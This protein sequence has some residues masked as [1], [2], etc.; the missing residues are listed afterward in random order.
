M[1]VLQECPVCNNKQSLK[2]IECKCGVNLVSKKKQGKIK[3]WIQYRLPGGKQRKEFVGYSIEDAKTADG[4]RK[5]QK[6]EGRIFDILPEAKTTFEQLADWY[7][8]LT[9]IKELGYYKDLKNN[10][11]SFNEV[12]GGGLN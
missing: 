3:Y 8:N 12:F 7:I 11:N 4:K 5:T 2:K 9:S 10:L 1:A 6:K